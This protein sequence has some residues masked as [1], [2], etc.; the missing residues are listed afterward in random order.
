[1]IRRLN[2]DGIQVQLEDLGNH[3][4][5][6]IISGYGNDCSTYWG[7]M[8]SEIKEFILGVN[9]DYFAN[10]LCRENYTFSIKE[11]FKNVRQYLRSETYELSGWYK[12]MEFQKDLRERLN[13]I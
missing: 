2:I 3:Q 6:I 5:T 10:R 12:H 8:G 13:E 1:M 11:T 7:A 9:G 4:G